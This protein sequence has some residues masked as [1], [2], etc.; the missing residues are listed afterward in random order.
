MVREGAITRRYS[1]NIIGRTYC[2]PSCNRCVL[3]CHCIVNEISFQ[4][5]QGN[6]ISDIVIETLTFCQVLEL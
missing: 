3:V 4:V 1:D 2:S 5:V 6:S